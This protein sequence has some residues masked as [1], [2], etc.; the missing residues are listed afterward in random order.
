[1]EQKNI[2]L[3]PDTILVTSSDCFLRKD[4]LDFKVKLEKS[5]KLVEYVDYEG[6][7]HAF[8]QSPVNENTKNLNHFLREK[9]QKHLLGKN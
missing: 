6:E 5:N 3:L 1:M 2:D 7:E 9:V 4:A 8:Y